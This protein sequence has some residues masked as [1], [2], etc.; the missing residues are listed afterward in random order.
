MVSTNTGTGTKPVV[1]FGRYNSLRTMTWTTPA[2]AT[3]DITGIYHVFA[4]NGVFQSYGYIFGAMSGTPDF[5]INEYSAGTPTSALWHPIE[6]STTA[7]RQGRTYLD[8]ERVDGT[9]TSPKSGWQLLEVALGTKTAHAANFFNDRNITAYG[10]RVGGDYLCEV[11]VFTN[12]LSETDR[13][14]VQRYLLEKWIGTKT[15]AP[16]AARA[17]ASGTVAAN[18][19]TNC[20]MTLRLSGEGTVQK[21]GPG[22]AVLEDVSS[23]TNLFRSAV[24][25]SGTLDLRVPV[26]L[27]LAAGS[28]ATTSN[29]AITVT[30]D[31]GTGEI[32]KEGSGTVTLTSLPTDLVRLN[33]NG[34]VLVL[35]PPS[36]STTVVAVVTGCVPNATFEAEPLTVYRR[37]IANG[38]TYYGWTADSP[39]VASG[40][41]NAVFIFNR[42]N[43]DTTK[44]PCDCAAP[45]SFQVLALKRDASASTTLTLPVSGVY[46]LSFYTSGRTNYGNH[47]FDICIVEGTATNHVATV[48]TIP[49]AYVRQTF[50]LPWLAAGDHTLLFHRIVKGMDS[51]GT[52]DD[53]KVTL[54][55]EMKPNIVSIPNG[56]FEL[57]DYPRTSSSFTTSNV[58]RGWTF[59]AATNGEVS[60][61]ITMAAS[62]AYYYTPSTPYGA[63]MLGLVSN[64]CA[65][66]TLT[67]P[68]GTYQ[69]WG[70]ICNWSCSLNGKYL[71]GTQTIK[72]T[73]TRDSGDSTTLGTLSTANARILTT[74]VWPTTFTATNNETVTLTLAGQTTAGPGLIDNLVLVPQTNAIVQNGSFEASANWTFSYNTAVQPKDAATYNDLSQSNYYGLAIYDGS[75]RLL[76]VQTGI[77]YQDIQIP[78]PG[79]YRLVF[80]AAQRCPLIY[81]N[82]YGHN[83]VRAWLA[84]NGTTNVIGWTRVDDTA[85]VR[86][87]FL[88]QAAEAGTYRFG[89]Q[90]VT[91]NSVE[92]P[93]TDQN[94]LIDGVSIKPADDLSPDGIPLPK[95]LALVV[96]EGARVQLSYVGTQTVD[97]I[98]YAGRL[99]S[100]VIDQTTHPEFVSGPGALYAAPKGSVI[101]L[102]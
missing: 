18:V 54:V 97:T 93:G 39:A 21:Q 17:S 4:V 48:Q 56:D 51:L 1:W 30:Q 72:A 65:W 83:P 96:A 53:L 46:D 85:L 74:R 58:A 86:H 40:A 50:R 11:V 26:P 16:V 49:A 64:G 69:L 55:S 10:K 82:V 79:L 47:E 38:E 100:G 92:F 90:G 27:S 25:Q 73:V 63:V 22:T 88:F 41:D 75:K 2:N 6:W 34:G 24:I 66:T 43:S 60:A 95:E 78:A 45:E 102:R 84:Q 7:L 9:I 32:T 19:A 12:R 5:H 36:I 15:I 99:V 101:L 42:S 98:S 35:T 91:D 89:L 71:Q 77:A 23:V 8:G 70:D 3:A 76:L 67:L 59:T 61:G 31:A 20:T 80:H 57:T 81:G 14:R 13:L 62:S 29:T 87:D 44:W 28:R 33:V 94:A 68:A 52:I 37:T